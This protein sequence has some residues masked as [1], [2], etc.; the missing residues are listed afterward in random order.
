[1]M[2]DHDSTVIDRLCD[3]VLI[4]KKG[5][6]VDRMVAIKELLDG[7]P[8]SHEITAIPKR[9]LTDREIKQLWPHYTRAGGTIRFYPKTRT[10]TQIIN[11]RILSSGFISRAETRSI[12]L[13]D[14]SIRIAEELDFAI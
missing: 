6:F 1:M 12:D 4:L 2:V 5:G 3:Q 10:E 13:N 11:T 7:L 14:Y 9:I 8:Y